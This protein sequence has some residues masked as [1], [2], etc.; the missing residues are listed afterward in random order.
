MFLLRYKNVLG[1]YFQFISTSIASSTSKFKVVL[2]CN[3]R[4]LS[5][6]PILF[7]IFDFVFVAEF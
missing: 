1:S 2:K 3:E 7:P 5:G 6:C 4:S